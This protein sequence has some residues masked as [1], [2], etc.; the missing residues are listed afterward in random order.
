MLVFFIGAVL[1]AL[2]NLAVLAGVAYN[3]SGEPEA[4][5]LLSEREFREPFF[6]GSDRENS[7]LAL[8]LSWRMAEGIRGTP[9]AWLDREKLSELGFEM[10]TQPGEDGRYRSMLLRQAWIV[11]EFDGPAHRAVIAKRETALAEAAARQADK[12][13]DA[14]LKS[15]LRHAE[16][17]LEEARERDSRLF[18][19][20]AGPDRHA[21]R[22]RYP[23]RAGYLILPGRVSMYYHANQ[24]SGS[25]TE[26][27]A[28]RFNVALEHR[29]AIQ[30]DGKYAVTVAFGKR[31][32]GWIVDAAGSDHEN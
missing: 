20:D 12:P 3:R 32:E 21:L 24:P 27:E 1:I 17:Q 4:V 13:D 8:H 23:E 14:Q 11:L 25:V 22:Q 9:A 30:P 5:T 7:G 31:G 2:G 15:L 10:S 19:I 18:A 28:D 16:K 6:Y 29:D 26:L